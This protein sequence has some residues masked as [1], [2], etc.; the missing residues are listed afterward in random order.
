LGKI[1]ILTVA[2]IQTELS[3]KTRISESIPNPHV[4]VPN[5]QQHAL[6]QEVPLWP[7]VNEQASFKVARVTKNWM[8]P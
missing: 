4:Q 8:P 1:T 7:L 3:R 5:M 2:S 6:F